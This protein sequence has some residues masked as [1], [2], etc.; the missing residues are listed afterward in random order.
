[1]REFDYRIELNVITYVTVFCFSQTSERDSLDEN[2]VVSV[3]TQD[4]GGNSSCN[5]YDTASF[6]L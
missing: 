6:T 5:R 4:G 3:Q 1:M 2:A